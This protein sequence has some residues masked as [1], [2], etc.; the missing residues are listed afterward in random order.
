MGDKTHISWSDATWNPITGCSKTSEG[1][2][3]CYID[4][5]PPFRMAHR[6]FDGPDIGA[7]TGVKLHSERLGIPMRWT[8]PRMI[9]VCSLADLFQ[10]EVPTQFIAEVFAVISIAEQHIFQVLTKRHGRMRS[11]L[12]SP[13][14]WAMVDAARAVRGYD[15]IPG[16]AP[17]AL[18]NAWIGVSTENQKWADL[19]IPALLATPAAVR[20]ISAEP[21]LGP[22]VLADDHSGHERDFQG[23]HYQ[24]LTCSTEENEVE[25]QTQEFPALDWI[26]CGGESGPKA[27]P[28]LPEW[29]QSLRD[30]CVRADVRYH[31]K[32]WG[33]WAPFVAGVAPGK[34]IRA[35][36]GAMVQ[37]VGKK[38]AGRLLEGREWD[39][40]PTA[41]GMAQ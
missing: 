22:I 20:W 6:K 15:L 40:F 27:R 3:N 16:Q 28:M 24:C 11:V 17:H 31:F 25:W 18:P 39:E 29:A 41:A 26:V 38:A 36:P 5:T 13:A 8:K 21:L 35:Y 32:Q 19:R 9:F 14:F 4:R 7:T 10:D 37:K 23:T 30:Q 12:N 33:E 34:E 1:C 2:L